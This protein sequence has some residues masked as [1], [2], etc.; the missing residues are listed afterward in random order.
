MKTPSIRPPRTLPF[1][2]PAYWTPEEAL[3]LVELLD[4]L[5]ELIWA[6]YELQLIDEFRE[7]NMPSRTK[8]LPTALTIRRSELP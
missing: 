7:Q 4:G 6:H 5:R 2:V 8:Y 1:A 3:A